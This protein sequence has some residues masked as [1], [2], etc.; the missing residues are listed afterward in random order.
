MQ[1]LILWILIEM[2]F[3]DIETEK[4][5][6]ALRQ[7]I[8]GFDHSALKKAETTEKNTLPTKESKY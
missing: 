8:E 4:E 2:S 5:H 1:L 7:G 6:Q 3:P